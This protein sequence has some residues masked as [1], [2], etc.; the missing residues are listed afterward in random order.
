MIY[1]EKPFLVPKVLS[2]KDYYS[3]ILE[4]KI[5]SFYND[6]LNPSFWTKKEQKGGKVTWEMDQRVRRK[7]LRIAEDF[8]SKFDEILSQKTILDVR[9]TGSLANYNY[10]PLSDLDVHVIVNLDGIDNENPKIL[11]AA[12]DGIRFV[13]NLRHNVVIRGYDV[14]LYIQDEKEEYTSSGVFSLTDNAWVKSPVFDP[15]EVDKSSVNKKFD[16]IVYEIEQLVTRLSSDSLPSNA[17]QLYERAIKIKE[18][19]QKMRKEGLKE[20]GEFSIGNLA[21][22]KLR[23]EGYIE[24][25]IGVISDSYNRIYTE[26]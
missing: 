5:G 6:E 21:F 24:K 18:K 9:L 22:K 16:S 1:K 26:N 12:L 23:N 2:Y 19:I 11:K 4:K 20:D 25:I 17:K 3:P 7:L 10:T 15:P 8:F 13:W 14:E